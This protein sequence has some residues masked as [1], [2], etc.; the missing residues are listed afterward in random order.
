M[1]STALVCALTASMG[2]GSLAYADDNDR[3]GRGHEPRFEQRWH[4]D[5]D[6]RHADRRD[7]RHGYYQGGHVSPRAYGHAWNDRYAHSPRGPQFHGGGY[8]PAEYRGRAHGVNDW[9]G[10]RLSAPP[11]GQQWVQVGTDYALIAL[12]TGLILNIALR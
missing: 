11:H 10:H 9:R 2:F 3:R 6:G 12:A 5:R 8:L 4:A 7:P 1:K